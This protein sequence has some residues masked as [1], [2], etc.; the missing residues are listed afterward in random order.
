M[1]SCGYLSLAET[2]SPCPASAA[3]D[4]LGLLVHFGISFVAVVDAAQL[5]GALRSFSKASCLRRRLCGIRAHWQHRNLPGLPPCVLAATPFSLCFAFV[6][7][8]IRRARH[9][10]RRLAAADDAGVGH[11]A[12]KCRPTR[13]RKYPTARRASRRRRDAHR[14]PT[15]VPRLPMPDWNCTRPCGRDHQQSIESDCA[16][17][18]ATERDANAAR[19]GADALRIARR[20][21]LPPELLCAAIECLLAGSNSS[22]SRACPW[23][24]GAELALC[25]QGNSR[26]A[27]AT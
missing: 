21:L 24:L 19:L 7:D 8:C 13:C 18:V 1:P 25:L 5:D 10:V 23:T 15:S 11:D 2:T 6:C 3:T 14:S 27:C 22:R 26:A 4:S 12:S 16:A 9:R 20:A 17:D